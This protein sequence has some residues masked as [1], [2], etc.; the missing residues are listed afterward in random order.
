MFPQKTVATDFPIYCEDLSEIWWLL[1]VWPVYKK[2]EK[3]SENLHMVVKGLLPR[4]FL[5]TG[6]KITRKNIYLQRA[7]IQVL[8]IAVRVVKGT[9]TNMTANKQTRNKKDSVHSTPYTV[10]CPA[11]LNKYNDAR[12][13]NR[14]VNCT[15]ISVV[16]CLVIELLI[17]LAS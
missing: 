3:V 16:N 14:A 4:Q 5:F 10:H 13:A 9:Q 8:C 12:I 1:T 11:T 15:Y 17:V 6:D 2:F 7:M